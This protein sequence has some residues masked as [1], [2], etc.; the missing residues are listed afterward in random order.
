MSLAESAGEDAKVLDIKLFENVVKLPQGPARSG[1]SWHVR[2]K[3]HGTDCVFKK[4]T[5]PMRPDEV[6]RSLSAI[7]T[8]WLTAGQHPNI[9]KFLGCTYN[10]EARQFVIATDYVDCLSLRE[11]M[12]DGV[13]LSEKVRHIARAVLARK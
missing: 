11:H 6:T 2:S 7:R 9:A 1:V 4:I 13:P 5:V 8:A 12:A 3:V 10:T